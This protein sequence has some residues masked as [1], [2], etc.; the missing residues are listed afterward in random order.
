M[1]AGIILSALSGAGNA[2]ADVA[3][4]QQKIAD[5]QALIQQRAALEEQK[6]KSIDLFR[7][8]L[9]N[10][11]AI[12]AGSYLKDAMSQQVPVQAAPVTALSGNDPN[13]PTDDSGNQTQGLVGNVGTT[14]SPQDLIQ[15][16]KAL[17]DDN[18][19]KA[20]LLAQV[21]RQLSADQATANAAV[22]GQTRAPT[23][24]E[25]LTTAISKAASNGDTRAYDSL[26]KLAAENYTTVP[27]S[28]LVDILNP[29]DRIDPTVSKMDLEKFKQDQLNNREKMRGETRM[30]IA[31]MNNDARSEVAKAKLAGQYP[32]ANSI[33]QSEKDVWVHQF[34]TNGSLSRNAPPVAK[35]NIA[36]WL[37]EKGITSEDV[38][39][40]VAQRKYDL[41]SAVTAGH[42]G[43][44]MKGVEAAIPALASNALDLSQK[45]DQGSFVPINKLMQMSES[46]ISDPTL[47]AFRVAHQALVSEYQQVISRGGTGSVE[48][49]KEAM[50]VINSAQSPEAYE[51]AVRQVL[52]EVKINVAAQNSVRSGMGGAE[53]G[54]QP[55]RTLPPVNIEPQNIQPV[56]QLPAI[57]PNQNGK[58]K[59]LN[60]NPATG[61]FQ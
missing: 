6:Q 38:D 2:A 20:P 60:Y 24:K 34:V 58:N 10:E 46:N 56:T 13:A 37:A 23:M 45:L 32:D 42:R 40:G 12:N 25:A 7:N 29:S 49:L 16:I 27:S 26:R 22:G 4:E 30:T 51:A 52:N 61:T 55:N 5:E 43:G 31:Q 9:A 48:A 8:Q 54:A 36:T 57:T 41:A 3:S 11:P 21:E 17:P 14:T 18:P 1:G 19:D 35:L 28:G 33:P 50:H 47:S 15:K 39:S 44:A 53:G 59:V